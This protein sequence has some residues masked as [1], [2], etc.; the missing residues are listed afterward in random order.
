M[1]LERGVLCQTLFSGVHQQSE[2]PQP[3]LANDRNGRHRKLG[4]VG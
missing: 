2:I 4:A 3:L 1:V